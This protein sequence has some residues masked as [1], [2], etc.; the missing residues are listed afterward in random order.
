MQGKSLWPLLTGKAPLDRHRDDVYA[1]HYGTIHRQ[2]GSPTAYATMIRTAEHKLVAAHGH[3]PGE[4]YDLRADP[5]ETVN[6]YADPAF[7]ATKA[8][9]Y[10]RL[11]DRMAWTVDPL[12]EREANY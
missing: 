4:L 9:L 8:E 7:A 10:R 12:P 2:P 3:A 6:R 5:G 11:C 1:E